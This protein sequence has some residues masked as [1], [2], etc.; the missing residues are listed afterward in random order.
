MIINFIFT[1][2]KYQITSKSSVFLWHVYFEQMNDKEK[3]LRP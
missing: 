3:A 1:P 2:E